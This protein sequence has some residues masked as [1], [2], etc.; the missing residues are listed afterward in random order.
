MAVKSYESASKGFTIEV[1]QELCEGLKD[2]I[3]VCPVD[4]YYLIEGKAV[5]TRIDACIEC[6][7]CVDSCPKGAIKHSSC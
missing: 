4:V 2:C 1:D 3:E 7:Q 5:P 6:C